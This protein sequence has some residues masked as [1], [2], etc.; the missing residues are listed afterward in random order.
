M[1]EAEMMFLEE[2][3]TSHGS[4]QT[5]PSQANF[6]LFVTWAWMVRRMYDALLRARGDCAPHP[7][8]DDSRDHWAAHGKPAVLASA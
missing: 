2:G 7:W 1:N 5:V 8:V 3:L 4:L 6:H